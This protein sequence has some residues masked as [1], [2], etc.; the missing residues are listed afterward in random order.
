MNPA[1][2][3]AF[4]T[5]FIS[6]SLEILWIRLF[7]FANQS[8]P[9]AFAFV[10]AVYLIGIAVGAYIGKCFCNTR[11]N[12]WIVSAVALLL[13]SIWNLAGPWAYV[14]ALG[15]PHPLLVGGM[16]ML[17]ASLFTAIVF[18]IA[19]HLG[20]ANN[21]H[22]G[23]NISHI[24]VAN[25]AGATLGPLVA[26][27]M[28]LAILTTQQSFIVCAVLAI[29][30]A[31]YCFYGTSKTGIVTAALALTAPL[32]MLYAFNSHVLI[33]KAAFV[34]SDKNPIIRIVENQYGIITLYRGNKADE[35]IVAGGN[36]YDGTTNLDPVYNS[37]S[38]NRV[39]IMSALVDQPKHVLMI[40]LSIGSWLKLVTTF[41]GIQSIDVIEINPGYQKI[42]AQYPAQESALRDPRVHLFVDDGRR[43]LKAHPDKRYDMVIMN[44][45][46]HWRAHTANLLSQEF[47]GLLKSH[48]NRN[49]VLEFNTTSSPD[50][51][52]TV[53]SIF[54]HA[55]LYQSTLPLRLIL[56]GVTNCIQN[57]LSKH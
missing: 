48:M 11:M 5:G 29:L 10:L 2:F 13:A 7:S 12:L 25:I 23:R 41:P 53:E 33:A 28:L 50:A 19:H 34:F 43:W 15:S 37:N 26:G 3:L 40:G 49:A 45:T 20:A 51:L 30:A 9:Q 24:Y 55:Y 42:I 17:M 54:K 32:V 38:I 39:T 44:T 46:Y 1:A 16:I 22:V 35:A 57:K 27:F 8:K 31:M 47:L 36:V 52:K 4:C 18:P 56:T 14:Q 21:L 6:L